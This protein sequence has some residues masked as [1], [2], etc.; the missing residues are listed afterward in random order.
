MTLNLNKNLTLYLIFFFSI[1]L[2]CCTTHKQHREVI[3][4][5]PIEVTGVPE[6]IDI[7]S[8]L[9]KTDAIR[10]TN[11]YL[12]AINIGSPRDSIFHV[13]QVPECKYLGKFGSIGK[14]PLDFVNP[15]TNTMGSTL[16]GIHIIDNMVFKDIRIDYTKNILSYTVNKNPLPGKLLIINGIIFLNSSTLI[17]HTTNSFIKKEL[18][19]YNMTDKSI[20]QFSDYPDLYKSSN[21]K[22]SSLYSLFLK[23]IAAKPD[24]TKFATLYDHFKQLKIYSTVKNEL[25]HDVTFKDSPEQKIEVRTE[26]TINTSMSYSFYLDMY[27]T[28]KYIYGLYLGKKPDE[29]NTDPTVNTDTQMHIWDW[30]GKPIALIKLKNT[31]FRI[32]VDANDEYFYTISP[33]HENALYKYDLKKI[34]KQN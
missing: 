11:N 17:G 9:T 26:G 32:A 27:A 1:I 31:E 3:D 29:I 22:S 16:N 7:P 10:I 21:I 24:G 14:G 4:N 34:L 6:I 12:V 20:Q 5:F 25:V 28:N 30:K 18:F 8:V 15:L 13:F 33:Y 19:S 23:H 2:T